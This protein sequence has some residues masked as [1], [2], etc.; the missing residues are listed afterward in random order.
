MNLKLILSIAAIAM[1]QALPA[2][3]V[4]RKGVVVKQPT[5][6]TELVAWYKIEDLKGYWKETSRKNNLNKNIP[7]A[8]TILL[9]ID[10]AN[11]LTR[12]MGT[13]GLDLKGVA[14]IEAPNF[15]NIAA[16]RYTILKVGKNSLQLNND[17]GNHN[18]IKVDKFPQGINYEAPK[19]DELKK[20]ETVDVA[21]LQGDWEVYRRDASPGYITDKTV[22]V[23]SF[24]IADINGKVATGTVNIYDGKNIIYSMSATYNFEAG[25]MEISMPD[26]I[27]SLTVYEA[28]EGTMIFGEKDGVMNYARKK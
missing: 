8:D 27:L 25:K 28:K 13:M 6:Q 5:A 14:M 1:A 3:R 7:Y 9:K 12:V 26:A 21:Q 24:T 18:F 20:V 17:D 4:K 10:A 2:Q 19:T 11:S 23:R 16:D 22:L 15:L